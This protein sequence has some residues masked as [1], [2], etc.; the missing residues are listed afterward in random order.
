MS[1][2][3]A[4]FHKGSEAGTLEAH[5]EPLVGQFHAEK[6][7]VRACLRNNGYTE[8]RAA[9]GV[10]KACMCGGGWISGTCVYEEGMLKKSPEPM[11]MPMPTP[12]PPV[13]QFATT[14]SL[15]NHIVMGMGG[16][17][18]GKVAV[19]TL[20]ERGLL[21]RAFMCQVP[22]SGSE[23]LLLG[24]LAALALLDISKFQH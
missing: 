23:Q 6:P 16:K 14:E 8:C 22:L 20:I 15:F 3:A 13:I 2:S 10:H 12:E 1:I 7:G 19:D 11:P 24:I 17:D 21:P 9:C 18:H 4:W 5:L